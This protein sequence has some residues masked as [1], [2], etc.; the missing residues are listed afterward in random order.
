MKDV[1]IN[2]ELSWLEFNHRVLMEAFREDVPLLEKFKFLSIVASNFDEFFMVRVATLRQEMKSGQPSSCPSGLSLEQ[3]KEKILARYQEIVQQQYKIFLENVLPSLAEEGVECLRPEDFNG[4]QQEFV[5]QYFN[6]ELFDI[7]SPVRVEEKRPFPY[8]GNLKLHLAFLLQKIDNPDNEREKMIILEIPSHLKRF[9]W[10]PVGNKRQAFCYIEDVI[11]KY[12]DRLTP[13][14]RVTEFLPF[15]LT[16]D[17]DTPVDEEGEVDFVEAMEKILEKRMHSSPVRLEIGTGSP[18]LRQRL[19][20]ALNIEPEAVFEMDGPLNLKDLFSL[21]LISN[22]SAHQFPPFEIYES[23]S[24]A[25]DIFEEIKRSDQLLH[26]PYDSFNPVIRLISEAAR[27]PQV[28]SIKM[29]LYRTSVNSPIIQALGEAARSG[30]QV[31]VLVEVKAR[32]DEEQNLN[33][34]ERLEKDGCIVIYG[35]ANLKVHAKALLIIRREERGVKRYVHLGTGNYHDKTAKLYTDIGL[36]SAR[37][38]LTQ[39]VSLFFNSITGYSALTPL[40][41]LVM[42]PNNLRKRI[43][44]LIRRSIEQKKAEPSVSIVAKLNSLADQELISALYRAS[45]AGV[46]I[47]LNIRGI[48]ML[49]PGVKGLSENIEVVSVV[50]RFLEHS[51]IYIFRAG[52]TEDIFY[53]LRIG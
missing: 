1:F 25:E 48:C 7:L 34:A 18:T 24:Q 6:Q 51:R 42:A 49:V 5:Q 40:R 47:K 52:E 30:K 22:M 35:L 14:Y 28:L 29:T 10:L 45:Q 23:M 53:H 32:F 36:L 50:G 37:D 21:S 8:T 39:E 38:D 26:H 41:Y 27:D 33:W 19:E 3:Q 13:G 17:A 11:A 31:T 46:K 9:L 2:R 16:R 20:E 15:R 4:E 12:L 43:L 44:G